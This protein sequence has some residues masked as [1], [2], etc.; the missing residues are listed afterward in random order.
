MPKY[1]ATI[2][3]HSIARAREIEIDGTLTL[4][5]RAATREFRGEFIDY[6]IVI[7]ADGDFARPVAARR[8]GNKRWQDSDF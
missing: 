7:Y 1:T 5:K 8:V 4:A 6:N 3:H 2:K